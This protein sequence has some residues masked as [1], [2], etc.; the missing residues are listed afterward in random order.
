MAIIII[1]AVT[2]DKETQQQRREAG[3]SGPL[4]FGAVELVMA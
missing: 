2:A 1:V 3:E 4:F